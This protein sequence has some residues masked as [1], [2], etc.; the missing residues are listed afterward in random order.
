MNFQVPQFIETEDKIIGPFTIRQFL[1]V[2]AAGAISFACFFFM[3]TWLWIIVTML[4]TAI[5]LSFAFL[6]ISGR[7]LPTILMAALGYYWKP[8]FYL[9]KKKE[10]IQKTGEVASPGFKPLE[11]MSKLDNLWDQI[12]TSKNPVPKREKSFQPTIMDRTRSSKER[13]EMMRKITGE[14]ELAKRI[15]YK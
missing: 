5:S 7:P 9:W 2:A 4:L 10:E 3:Q 8:R 12:K 1:Y 15:D 11:I 6:K 13:F 14:K